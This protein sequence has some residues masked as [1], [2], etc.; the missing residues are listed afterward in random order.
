MKCC[1]FTEC[2][3]GI[4]SCVCCVMQKTHRLSVLKLL[5]GQDLLLEG[6]IHPLVLR[7]LPEAFK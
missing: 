1:W 5:V 4:N 3:C 6:N 7:M 2:V